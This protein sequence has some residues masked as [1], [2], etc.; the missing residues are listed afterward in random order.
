M[1]DDKVVDIRPDLDDT[2]LLANRQLQRRIE[3]MTRTAEVAQIPMAVVLIED[4][5][6][7]FFTNPTAEVDYL[8]MCG[9]MDELKAY[10]RGDSMFVVAE[11]ESEDD[12]G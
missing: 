2:R 5:T 6:A 9:A 3:A 12:A 8:A 4:G 10:L 11:E 1:T 7:A